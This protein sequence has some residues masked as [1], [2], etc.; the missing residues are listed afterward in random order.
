MLRNH[1]RHTSS[2]SAFLG[3]CA[4]LGDKATQQLSGRFRGRL[5]FQDLLAA[6]YNEACNHANTPHAHLAA[7]MP[8]VLAG[9]Q[10]PPQLKAALSRAPPT[11]NARRAAREAR[12]A[13]DGAARA[14]QDE[15]WRLEGGL[16]ALRELAEHC[17]RDWSERSLEMC[18]PRHARAH[19]PNPSPF[20]RAR[21]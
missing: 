1:R 16:S 8:A 2:Y 10:L 5:L 20:P 4:K 13:A 14:A 11:P 15:V 17:G 12:R 7:T 18:A 9:L 3:G 19:A 6:Q 21:I